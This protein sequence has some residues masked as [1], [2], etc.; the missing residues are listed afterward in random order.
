M[1]R[2][3]KG[4]WQKMRHTPLLYLHFWI[5]LLSLAVFL[6]YFW[7]AR[8]EPEKEVY[9][10]VEVLGT[11][12]P[13]LSAVISQL[14][15]ELEEPGHCQLL[16][17][18]SGRKWKALAGKWAALLLLSFGSAMLAEAG[19]GLLYGILT[20]DYP[21]HMQVYFLLALAL[22]GGQVSVYLLHLMLGL[23]FGRGASIIIGV[24]EAVLAA[25]L[26]TGLGDG[27]WMF[28]PCAFSG[29]WSSYM[30]L[31][32]RNLKV[33][34]DFKRGFMV[35]GIVVVLVAAAVFVWFHFY[36]GRRCGD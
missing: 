31:Y 15:V 33:A 18:G 7:Y 11:A 23:V 35:S 28:I 13:L 21:F 19:F 32:E 17:L 3:V 8:R 5:P 30:L 29:R 12:Y 16:F 10:Y 34:A 24:G 2:M 36:E 4:E 26:L 6:P 25:L 20:G 9:A 27:R 22:W 14:S 1:L